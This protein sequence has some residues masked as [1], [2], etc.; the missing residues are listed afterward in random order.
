MVNEQIGM[1]GQARPTN[2]FDGLFPF[3]GVRVFDGSSLN[4]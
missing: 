2:Q 4:K 1:M 3:H